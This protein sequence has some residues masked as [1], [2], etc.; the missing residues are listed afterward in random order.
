MGRINRIISIFGALAL[1]VFAVNFAFA[2]SAFAIGGGGISSVTG[3]AVN[4]NGENTC[5]KKIGDTAHIT[6]NVYSSMLFTSADSSSYVRKTS[7]FVPNVLQN[8]KVT[9]VSVPDTEEYKKILAKRP[10]TPTGNPEPPVPVR[11]VNKTVPIVDFMPD[12]NGEFRDEQGN[13]LSS[14]KGGLLVSDVNDTNLGVYRSGSYASEDPNHPEV[15]YLN[16]RSGEQ[17]ME[18]HNL[19]HEYSFEIKEHGVFTLKIEGD[20]KIQSKLTV[21]PVRV[22]NTTSKCANESG[23]G[24]EEDCQDMTEYAQWQRGA[25]PYYSL[26]NATV[27]KKLFEKNTPDGL[28]GSERCAVTRENQ[29]NNMIGE[30]VTPNKNSVYEAYV[31]TFSL[32]SNPAVHYFLNGVKEDGCDQAAAVVTLCPEEPIPVPNPDPAPNPRPAPT[33]DPTPNP[34][35]PTPD[36]T[37]NPPTPELKPQ[38]E[39]PAPKPWPE[40]RIGIIPKTGGSASFASLLAALGFSIAGLAILR[41]KKMMEENK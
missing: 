39:T 24:Y 21:L 23:G 14:A 2:Q 27:N 31:K 32:E 36:P 7:V 6:Y 17:G 15:A 40:K 8:V 34:P 37:P 38:P 13:D 26:T 1:T 35:A 19:Y 22:T 30:D 20:V 16:Y 29:M 3:G 33:P 41:K 28:A 5:V 12:Q 18:N 10:P 11:M 25:L 4:C 9:L